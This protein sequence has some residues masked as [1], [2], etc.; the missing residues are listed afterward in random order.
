M[1][2]SH[3]QSKIG[4]LILAFSL[5]F[6]L[7]V[8]SG[9]TAQAQYQDDYWRQQ[10][11]YQREQQRRQREY[12]REQIRRQ[13]ERERAYGYGNN[14]YGNDVYSNNGYGNYNYGVAAQV[15]QTALNA[16][17][18]EGIREGR[19]DRSRGRGFDYAD[20]STYRNAT[21]DYNSRY[22]DQ[23]FYRQYFRQGFVNGYTDGYRGY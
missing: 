5:L 13:R 3:L 10:R 21:K 7:V 2:S 15:R 11:Q 18:N 4:R 19:N 20:S 12:Q 6:G 17:Y 1:N 8:A 23:E 9:I 14:G 16:G 22:G